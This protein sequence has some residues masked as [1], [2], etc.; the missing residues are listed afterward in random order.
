MVQAPDSRNRNDAAVGRRSD[1]PG[2]GC[3]FVKRKIAVA[4]FAQAVN[5]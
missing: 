3:V 4:V 1:K 2:D 5:G